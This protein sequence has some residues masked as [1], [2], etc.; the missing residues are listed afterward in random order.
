MALQSRLSL[1]AACALLLLAPR[2]L[3]GFWPSDYNYQP[4]S[5]FLAVTACICLLMALRTTQNSRKF[6]AVAGLLSAFFG[7]SC[8]SLITGVYMHDGL[9]E[10]TRVAAVIAWF[11][12]IRTLLLESTEDSVYLYLLSAITGGALIVCVPAIIDFIQTRNPRQFS[13]FYN[14]NLFANYCAM[15]LPLALAWGIGLFRLKSQASLPRPLLIAIAVLPSLIIIVGLLVTS[16]KGGLLAMAAGLLMFLL[17]VWRAQGE[18]LKEIMRARRS[19]LIIVA[20]VLL[21]AGGA[22]AS[23]TVLPRLQQLRG[24]DDNSTM[25]RYYTWQGTLHM[26]AA[27]PLLGWGAG[28]F[29]SAY[30]QFAIT[31][32]TRSAHQLWL[33]IAA[34]NGLPALLLMIGVCAAAGMQAWRALRSTGWPVAAGGLGALA[35]FIVHGLTDAGWGITS[36]A[37]LLLVVLALLD[38][39]RLRHDEP[40]SKPDAAVSPQR[41]AISWPWIIASL[42]LGLA[43]AGVQRAVLADDLWIEWSRHRDAGENALALQ[44]ARDASQADPLGAR[45]WSALGHAQDANKEDARA[46]YQRAIHL[47]PTHAAHSRNVAEYLAALQA[48]DSKSTTPQNIRQLFDRAVALEPNETKSRLARA[49][50]LLSRNDPQGWKDLEYIAHLASQPY[51]KYPAVMDIVNLDFA[52]AYIQLAE[53]TL[54]NNQKE[55]ARSLI[56]RGLQDVARARTHE[57]RQRQMAEEMVGTGI[58]VGPARDLGELELNLND[59]KEH[60]E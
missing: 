16:S 6:G 51:G 42:L 14:P 58:N 48:K 32:Y 15:A 31:G 5:T 21:I 29:P 4:Q 1:I 22:V 19:T 18:R 49:R 28:S 27:R 20:L 50:W 34:E 43:S 12:I 3:S 54:R 8:L 52:R 40:E 41:S 44:K 46:A 11:F 47:Q 30:S 59:L 9:L 17:A 57:A 24:T 26:A 33:Q 7:W 56:E 10:T 45:M 2:G 55:K 53:H 37:L 39:T 13:A 36:I 23:L 38:T 25:F 35:A 60:A